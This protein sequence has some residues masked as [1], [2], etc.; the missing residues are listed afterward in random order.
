MESVSDNVEKI[1]KP[2]FINNYSLCGLQED[3]VNSGI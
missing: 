3:P 1:L 2:I